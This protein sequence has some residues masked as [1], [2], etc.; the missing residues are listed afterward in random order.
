MSNHDVG[1]ALNKGL[2]KLDELGVFDIVGKESA[3]KIALEFARIANGWDGNAYEV[4]EGLEDYFGICACCLK[5][6]EDLKDGYCVEC[7]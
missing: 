4:L 1:Y 2:R 5:K 7:R 3:S 6:N